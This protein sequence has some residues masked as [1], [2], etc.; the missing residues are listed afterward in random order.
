MDRDPLLITSDDE[1][2][3][4]DPLEGRLPMH[5][6]CASHTLSLCATV[7]ANKMLESQDTELSIMH[8]QVLKKCNNLWKSGNRPKSAEIIQNVLGHALSKPGETRWNSLYDA[9]KQILMTKEK[10]TALHRS[11]N[12]KNP[13]REAEFDYI[14]EYLT[15]TKPIAEALDILQGENATYYG[16]LLPTLLALRRKLRNLANENSTYCGPLIQTYLE[17]VE[18]RF[19]EYFKISTPQAEDA[20]VAAMSYPRF[21]KFKWLSCVDQARYA[22]LKNLFTTAIWKEIIPE[23]NTANKP[24]SEPKEE[25][26]FYIDSD[27]DCENQ[28]SHPRSKAELII[29]HFSA[30][31]SKDLNILNNYPEIK[32]VFLRYNTPLPSSAPVERMFSYATITNCPK[33]NRLADEMFQKRV[34]LKA[35]LSYEKNLGNKQK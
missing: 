30:E 7:D 3:L 19:E 4:A 5:F 11:L 21:N 33:A 35:N 23:E 10:T 27:S 22:K 28:N 32:R 18:R 17:S 31:E 12:I 15:C 8:Q 26:F 20:A 9:L 14:Q 6:R 34:I 1:L 2:P 24:S 16:I 25:D 13:L 29:A